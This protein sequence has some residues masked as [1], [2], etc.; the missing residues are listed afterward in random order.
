MPY[1]GGKTA[2]RPGNKRHRKVLRDNIFGI[3]KPAIRRLCRRGGVKRIN[4]LVYDETRG[5]IKEWLGHIVELSSFYIENARRKTVT[6]M[7]VMH[8]LDRKGMTFYSS[9]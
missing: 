6:P 7:D 5:I 1:H 8:A 9:H 4:N 3:T 2:P